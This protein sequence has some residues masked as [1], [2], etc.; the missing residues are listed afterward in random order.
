M[1]KDYLEEALNLFKNGFH[2]SQSVLTPFCENFG[3]PKETALKISSPFGGGFGG[4][5]KTCGALTGAMMVIGLKYG[6]TNINDT[7][8]KKI[9]TDKTRELIARFEE[10]HGSCVCNDLVGFDRSNLSAA[11]LLTKLQFFHSH[12]TKFLETAVT[13]LEE[14]L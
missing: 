11:E 3:L 10:V 1:V 8:T 5:G 2:C 12:C 13:F 4:C 14:E 6:V 9:C 7:E